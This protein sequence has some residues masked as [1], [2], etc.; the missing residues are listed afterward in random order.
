M[1]PLHRFNL[2]IRHFFMALLNKKKKLFLEWYFNVEE[3]EGEQG[4]QFFVFQSSLYSLGLLH[5]FYSIYSQSHLFS[6]LVK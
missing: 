5:L 6:N 4:T 3:K 2:P 1:C